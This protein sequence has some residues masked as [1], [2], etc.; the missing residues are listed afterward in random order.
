MSQTPLS[1]A[2][3]T[4]NGSATYQNDPTLSPVMQLSIAIANAP[5]GTNPTLQFTVSESDDNVLYQTKY[6]SQVFTAQQA[7]AIPSH[8]SRMYSTL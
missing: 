4:T 1:N 2:T 7:T 6:T 8:R 3:V 5:T